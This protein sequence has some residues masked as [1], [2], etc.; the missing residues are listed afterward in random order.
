MLAEVLLMLVNIIGFLAALTS[1]ISL[2]PQIIK[3]RKTRSVE[4]ISTSM[5]L[6][7]LATSALWIIYGLMITSWS[8][9]L[10]NIFMLICAIIMIYL[11][12]KY[13]VTSAAKF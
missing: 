8:V 2:I 9:W 11:K 6:N 5:A 3:M 4:D 7:F 13:R 10:T 1:T 12:I